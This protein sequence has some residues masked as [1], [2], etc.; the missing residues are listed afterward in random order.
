MKTVIVRKYENISLT[1]TVSQD[2]IDLLSET[3]KA[4]QKVHLELWELQLHQGI[5]EIMRDL[6]GLSSLDSNES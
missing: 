6:E 4:F 2:L 5:A 1:V 3:P